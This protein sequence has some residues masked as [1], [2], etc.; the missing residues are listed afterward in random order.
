[1]L[2]ASARWASIIA[3]TISPLPS[4]ISWELTARRNTSLPTAALSSSIIMANRS[5]RRWRNLHAVAVACTVALLAGLF[6]RPAS[7]QLL[8]YPDP[9]LDSIYPA[10]GRQGATVDVELRGL[11]GLSGASELV[12]DG[13][14]S[15][16][17]SQVKATGPDRVT[18]TLAIAADAAPG[19]RR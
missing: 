14:P 17:A 11:N 10:G 8:Q 5:M 7:A 6:T 18:A 12:I 2:A 1:M 13:P 19:R 4:T 3:R 9:S 16:I 15:V